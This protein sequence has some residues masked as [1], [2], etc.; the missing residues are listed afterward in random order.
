MIE[1]AGARGIDRESVKNAAAITPAVLVIQNVAALKPAAKDLRSA[2]R[3]NF[4]SADAASNGANVTGLSIS[5]AGNTMKALTGIHNLVPNG[6]SFAIGQA[7]TAGL[8]VTAVASGVIGIHKAYRTYKGFIFYTKLWNAIEDPQKGLLHFLIEQLTL[9]EDEKQLR[10]DVQAKILQKKE[11]DFERMLKSGQDKKKHPNK[12]FLERAQAILKEYDAI[13]GTAT[14]PSKELVEKSQVLA[15]DMAKQSFKNGMKDAVDTFLC[16]V[17]VMGAATAAPS[18]GISLG[19]AGGISLVTV[20]VK[21]GRIQAAWKKM[22]F[23][24][25]GSTFIQRMN[26]NFRPE[27][28]NGASDAINDL[29]HVA[30]DFIEDLKAHALRQRGNSGCDF[31]GNNHGR[32]IKHSDEFFDC[33]LE[34]EHSDEFFDSFLEPEDSDDFFDCWND[35]LLREYDFNAAPKVNNDWHLP[36]DEEGFSV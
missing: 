33:F 24:R 30:V 22:E 1:A 23:M 20:L 27:W 18:H 5:A 36:E 31:K 32:P 14:P 13:R 25:P 17:G 6:T 9:T 2:V 8:P 21:K 29:H 16:T 7:A 11:N 12:Q 35:D 4:A 34:P 15:F 26:V 19:V 3:Y 10:P 28:A